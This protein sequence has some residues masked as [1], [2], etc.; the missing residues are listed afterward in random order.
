[1][2]RTLDEGENM[3]CYCPDDCNCHSPWRTNYCGCRQHEE[4]QAAREAYAP[5]PRDYTCRC[6]MAACTCG[7]PYADAP[8]A[9]Q[10]SLRDILEGRWF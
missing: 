4:R 3:H 6:Q 8:L 10:R 7:P 1:M 9:R 2:H 5:A